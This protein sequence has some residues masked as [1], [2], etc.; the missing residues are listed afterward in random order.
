MKR[1]FNYLNKPSASLNTEFARRRVA[2]SMPGETAA[3]AS[4]RYGGMA[5]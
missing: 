4:L 5:L 2:R 3:L 1:L